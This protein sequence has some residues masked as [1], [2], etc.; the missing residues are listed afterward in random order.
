M[1]VSAMLWTGLAI[2]FSVAQAQTS[3]IGPAPLV[4]DAAVGDPVT[5]VAATRAVPRLVDT[6]NDAVVADLYLTVFEDHPVPAHEWSGNVDTCNAG[7]VSA[8]YRQATLT[9]VN[10]YR[11]MVGLPPVTFDATNNAKCQKAALMMVANNAL[12]HFPPSS[13]ACYTAD[14]AEAAG[15]SNL[16]LGS[17]TNAAGPYAINGYIN[18]P[19]ASNGAVGHR[20]WVLYPPKQVMAGG[21]VITSSKAANALWVVS[22]GNGTRPATPA[23]VPW[24][25][26]GYFPYQ[27]LPSSTRW[28]FSV[29]GADFSGSTVTLKDGSGANYSITMETLDNAGYGDRTLV[30]K[31]SGIPTAKPAADITY[32]VT[33]A[34]VVTGSETKSYTYDVIVFDPAGRRNPGSN[35]AP[36]AAFSASPTSGPAPLDVAL[37][38]SASTDS[39]GTIASYAWTYGDGSTG[40]GATGTH[41][42]QGAGTYTVTLTVTD[43]V[44]ATDSA[45]ASITVGGGGGGSYTS[46]SDTDTDSDGFPDELEEALGTSAS[47]GNDAPIAGWGGTPEPLTLERVTVKLNFAS[48]GLDSVTIKGTLPV[49]AGF[50]VASQRV[51]L[52]AGG[53]IKGIILDEKGRYAE[54]VVKFTLRVKSI[55]GAVEAQDARFTARISRDAFKEELA[56]EGLLGDQTVSNEERTVPIIILFDETLLRTDHVVNYSAKAEKKGAAST[57]R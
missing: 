20:R 48:D 22:G 54:G 18:D 35:Q 28:S 16:Y 37:D 31:P 41:T 13:W 27:L 52:D 2:G 56:D 7:D 46:N 30:F 24:P 21:D 4:N 5:E 8:A 40:T 9:R 23:F 3:S 49:P 51:D 6:S 57:P 53:V 44:G 19:G 47:D 12:N 34:N 14:G 11:E 55:K 43:N 32:T 15:N 42:F 50:S 45:T 25:S 38:A 10:F 33:V 26:K 39:D 36:Q 1:N 17:A 29:N